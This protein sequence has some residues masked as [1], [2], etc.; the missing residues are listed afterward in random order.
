M[1]R[2]LFSSYCFYLQLRYALGLQQVMSPM[3]GSTEHTTKTPG[4]VAR[5]TSGGG[6]P[7]RVPIPVTASAVV[8]DTS[9]QKTSDYKILAALATVTERLATL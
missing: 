5:R 7:A 9:A 3:A 1:R 2:I 6:S 8:E 4:G